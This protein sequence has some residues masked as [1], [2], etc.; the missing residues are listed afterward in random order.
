[1]IESFCIW[2]DDVIIAT[3]SEESLKSGK[4]MLKEKFKMKD[5]GVLKHFLGIDC[6]QGK[7]IKLNQTRYKRKILERFDMS[8]CKPHSTPCEQRL[9][10]EAD[11]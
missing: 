7:E 8:D 9:N 11:G 6:K 1:M 2:V 5:L 3:D 10:F 4:E